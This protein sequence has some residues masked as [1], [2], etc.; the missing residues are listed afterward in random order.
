MKKIFLIMLILFTVILSGCTSNNPNILTLEEANDLKEKIVK[1]YQKETET[2]K[3]IKDIEIT[4]YY[5][6]YNGAYVLSI[7][8]GNDGGI[9]EIIKENIADFT[10]EYPGTRKIDVL[11][12]NKVYSFKDAYE[13]D[14]LKKEDI[15]KIYNKYKE[16]GGYTATYGYDY[17][18]NG[19]DY[20]ICDFDIDGI[21]LVDKDMKKIDIYQDIQYIS[22]KDYDNK[23]I[24]G[25]LEKY[26]EYFDINE[27]IK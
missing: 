11:Y 7:L 2:K 13:K 16:V 19:Y 20:V 17:F 4:D 10:F 1:Y 26:N 27:Y 12:R 22:L 6:E 5:G 14:I 25:L 9:P 21:V 23:K 24:V 8:G 18:N 15:Y 3:D